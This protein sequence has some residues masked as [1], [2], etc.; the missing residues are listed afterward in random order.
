MGNFM[1]TPRARAARN[2]RS[3]FSNV[4]V[5]E[6][7][8][9]QGAQPV[10]RENAQVCPRSLR[11]QPPRLHHFSPLLLSDNITFEIRS[12]SPRKPSCNPLK[13]CRFIKVL[14]PPLRLRCP[15]LASG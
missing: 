11:S 12:A 7:E 15:P 8:P 2:S 1:T 10:E 4:I 9:A 5:N 14:L 6:N 3:S 13:A